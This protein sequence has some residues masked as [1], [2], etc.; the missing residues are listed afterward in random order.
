MRAGY[1]QIKKLTF[2]NN[3]THILVTILFLVP[4]CNLSA[5]TPRLLKILYNET[6]YDGEVSQ[7]F[8]TTSFTYNDAGDVQIVEDDYNRV[9]YNYDLA[10]NKITLTTYSKEDDGSTILEGTNVLTLKDGLVVKGDVNTTDDEGTPVQ[11]TILFYYENGYLTKGVAYIEGEDSTI[12]ALTWKDGNITEAYDTDTHYWYTYNNQIRKST[13][14]DAYCDAPFST[15]ASLD[16]AP[17]L[18]AKGYFGKG[19]QEPYTKH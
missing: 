16:L 13:M 15:C 6:D 8:E 1:L 4:I 17:H 19:N 18:V 2:M 10:N 14:A 7:S 5:Q 11:G 9:Y 12:F 3:L